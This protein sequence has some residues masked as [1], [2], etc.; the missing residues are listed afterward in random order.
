MFARNLGPDAVDAL[1]N[2][3]LFREHLSTDIKNGDVFPAIRNG[4]IDFYCGGGR[5]FKFEGQKFETHR[6]YAPVLQSTSGD[7]YLTEDQMRDVKAVISFE[8]AYSGM[9]DNC[10]SY[11]GEEALGVSA[12]CLRYSFAALKEKAGVV[13]LDIEVAFSNEGGGTP[14]RMDMLL[15]NRSTFEL[16]FIEAK[17]FS[18][19]EIWAQRGRLPKVR[20]QL[21]RYSRHLSARNQDVILEQYRAYISICKGLFD[22]DLPAPKAIDPAIGLLIFGFD[23]SQKIRLGEMLAEGGFN[24]VPLYCKGEV[25]TLNAATL[26]NETSKPLKV[27]RL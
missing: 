4:Y 3:S 26:W 1:R 25:N 27:P 22:L 9:K 8:E 6:K 20:K 15:F 21:E 12:I 5:L 10:R 7:D 23:Q 17:H 19:P 24:G 14:D 18:N 13:V 2:R 16:R 11:A